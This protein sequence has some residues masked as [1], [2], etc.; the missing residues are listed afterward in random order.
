MK[1]PK[2]AILLLNYLSIATASSVFITPALPK[3]EKFYQ[4]SNGQIE[5]VI[6]IFLLGYMLAQLIYGP[7][8]NRYGR[9][10]ALRIGLCLN[11]LGIVI[12]LAG[13]WFACYPLLLIGRLITALGAASGLVCT[14]ILVNETYPPEKAK[15]IIT[16]APHFF[17]LR[18]IPRHFNRWIHHRPFRLAILLCFFKPTWHSI[19]VCQFLFI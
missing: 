7:I 15:R 6:S 14:F 12:C 16:Y 3:L 11:L 5:W 1:L 19:M 4:L 13:F 17:C 9:L 18:Y 8:A 10:Q 2:H